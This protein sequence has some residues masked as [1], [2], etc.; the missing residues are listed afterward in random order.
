MAVPSNRRR[1]QRIQPFVAPCRYVVGEARHA[2][3]LTDISREGGRVN[4]DI[5]PPEIG[6][7]IVVELRVPRQ[8]L[9]LRLPATVRWSRASDSRAVI[10]F[11]KFC[12]SSN[13]GTAPYLAT[14]PGPAL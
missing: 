9:A 12:V 13:G 7:T 2:G 11:T 5:E 4:A 8:A 6:Q 3:F 14:V 1:S 10:L